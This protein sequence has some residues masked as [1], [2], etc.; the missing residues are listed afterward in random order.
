M[1]SRFGDVPV[2][3]CAYS[4]VTRT[5]ARMLTQNICAHIHIHD[6]QNTR[7]R[8]HTHTRRQKESERERF[9]H[10]SVRGSIII[11]HVISDNLRAGTWEERSGLHKSSSV[12][13]AESSVS[14]R[15]RK[16]QPCCT[17]VT[18]TLPPHFSPCVPPA[19]TNYILSCL[20]VFS[21]AWCDCLASSCE[22]DAAWSETFG[23]L[24]KV[25]DRVSEGSFRS[26]V[27][28]SPVSSAPLKAFCS[29]LVRDHDGVS[30]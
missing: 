15:R 28:D 14:R 1:R 4:T 9:N 11:S 5:H 27:T 24:F 13:R 7:A 19:Y 10:Q 3:L 18:K 2:E 6:I 20:S 29:Q 26:E 17:A 8:T 23:F 21:S 16:S 25:K 12:G 30:S 22:T